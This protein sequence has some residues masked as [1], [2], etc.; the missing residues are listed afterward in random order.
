MYTRPDARDHRRQCRRGVGQARGD[1][2]LGE[3][4]PVVPQVDQPSPLRKGS[5]ARAQRTTGDDPQ[6]K[7]PSRVRTFRT[8]SPEVPVRHSSD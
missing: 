5:Q 2:H 4:N 3:M 6:R 7:L 8:L 1:R